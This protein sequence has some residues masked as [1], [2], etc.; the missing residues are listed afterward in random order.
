MGV[1][2]I[3]LISEAEGTSHLD[4]HSPLDQI[5]KII[6]TILSFLFLERMG[7]EQSGFS[8]LEAPKAEMNAVLQVGV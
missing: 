4:S 5:A 6:Q 1:L 3:R 8:V 7:K 2:S